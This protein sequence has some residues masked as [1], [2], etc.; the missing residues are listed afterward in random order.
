MNC[1]SCDTCVYHLRFVFVFWGGIP[2]LQ[3]D[4]S[5]SCDHHGLDYARTTTLAG[6]L[7]RRQTAVENCE[8]FIKNISRTSAVSSTNFGSILIFASCVVG[9]FAPTASMLYMFFSSR[10]VWPHVSFV[11]HHSLPNASDTRSARCCCRSLCVRVLYQRKS[12]ARS[13]V[14]HCSSIMR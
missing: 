12:L 9:L 13:A 10:F 3:S 14:Y 2:Q 7:C 11:C 5:L 6:N 1:V 8:N 4:W